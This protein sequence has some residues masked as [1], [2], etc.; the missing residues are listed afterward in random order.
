MKMV[1]YGVDRLH[2]LGYSCDAVSNIASQG[3][4]SMISTSLNLRSFVFGAIMAVL[5]T[6]HA[7]SSPID[8][9]PPFPPGTD[10]LTAMVS[11][12]DPLPPFPP[13]TDD[14]TAMV[15]PIDPLPPFPP[16]TDDMTAK[17]SPIDPLPPFP[18]GTDDLTA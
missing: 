3:A 12:I 10:D 16:G 15:S 4:K 13:G 6:G 9:L 1:T 5:A 7:L 18:P 2:T 8:P 17:A 11:P 14:L